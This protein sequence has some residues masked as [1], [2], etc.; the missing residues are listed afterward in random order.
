MGLTRFKSSNLVS[1]IVNLVNSLRAENT[2]LQGQVR[3]LAGE[4]DNLR[5]K[6]RALEI[7]QARPRKEEDERQQH[8]EVEHTES[9]KVEHEQASTEAST[10]ATPTIPSS[11]TKRK[12]KKRVRIE[13]KLK[14]L[15]VLKTTVLIPHEVKA[16]PDLW[17]EIDSPVVTRE[18]IVKPTTL[19]VHEIVRKKYRSKIDRTDAPIIAKAPIRF[20][21][22]YISSSLAIYVT[23]SKYLEHNPLYRL[24]KKF[25]RLGVEISRQS[26]SDIIKQMAEWLE[27]LYK[28]IDQSAK[29]SA[30][31]QIDETFIKYINGNLPGVGQ[32]YFWTIHSPGHCMVLKWIDNRRHENVD[33]LING[34][35]GILQSDAYAAYANYAALH[36]GITMAACWAHAFRKFRDGIEH[37][38]AHAKLVMGLISEMYK[39]EEEWDKKAVSDEERTVL[40]A[41]HSMPIA[42]TIKT[43][44]DAYAVDMTIPNNKFREALT[45]AANHWSKLEECLKHGHIRLDT[46]LLESK[47]RPTKI[48]E[49]NWMFIGHPDAGQKSA[50][51]YSIINTCAIHRIDP[52]K[53]L[54]D[55]LSQLFPADRQ[56]TEQLLESLMPEN[57]A[58]THP[59]KLIKEPC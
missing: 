3:E 57:W 38:P 7:V 26:Q 28:R 11:S 54:E 4:V 15:P 42:Q 29:E 55:V 23:L 13:A 51:I 44:L 50:I 46:N 16:N 19:G 31:L 52:R 12:G 30:Y 58:K 1:V 45:Y 24:E 49:K 43:K 9:V 2:S 20:S 17:D 35:N 22:S 36:P 10:E 59:D 21:S 27:P 40:R 14:D 48:G 33:T 41:E 39:L 47:F 8:L 53:Y 34:F 56:P 6:I 18:V 5:M 37:E 32:G 25:I